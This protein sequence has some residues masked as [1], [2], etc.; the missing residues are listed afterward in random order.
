[1]SDAPRVVTFT[2]APAFDRV[3]SLGELSPGSVNRVPSPLVRLAGKGVNVTATLH[4]GGHTSS[5]A[6]VL[7]DASWPVLDEPWLRIVEQTG[8]GRWNT[9]LVEESG[10]TTNIN[11][12]PAPL[13]SSDWARACA[14]V[15][16]EVDRSCADWLVIGGMMPLVD[17]AAPDLATLQHGLAA[18]GTQLCL[19]TSGATLSEWLRAGVRP[20]LVKPNR[21]ELA[22]TTGTNIQTMG[23]MRI[24]AHRLRRMGARAILSSMGSDGLL[25][26]GEGEERWC[27]APFVEIRNTTGAGDASLAGFLSATAFG[28]DRALEIA[29]S[30]GALTVTSLSPVADSLRVLDAARVRPLIESHV[31]TG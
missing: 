12:T 25:Y 29:A 1:M 15:L 7:L 21:Q 30:W 8:A 11:E 24:A 18:S 17:G 2:P 20:D 23:D 22:E 10:R 19:D 6:I 9:V 4:Q 5:R 14:S 26:V 31:L 16:E 27:P 13:T 3:Y 28:H